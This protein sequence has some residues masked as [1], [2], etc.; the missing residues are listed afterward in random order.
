MNGIEAYMPGKARD[1]DFSWT[2]TIIFYFRRMQ[3]IGPDV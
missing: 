1:T 2:R 3:T